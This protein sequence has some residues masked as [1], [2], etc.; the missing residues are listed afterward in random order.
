MRPQATIRPNLFIIGAAKAGTTTLH[1][2]LAAH[3]DVFMSEPKEPGYFTPEVGYYP[4][5]LEWY[6][7]LFKEAGDATIVGEAST[8]YTKRP[9]YEGVPKRIAE[10]CPDARFIYLMRDPVDRAVSHYWHEVRKLNEHRSIFGAIQEDLRYTCLGDYQYQL[11]PY[12]DRF[13]R[14]RVLVLTFEELVSEPDAVLPGVYQWL[15]LDH[16][17]GGIEL[18]RENARPPAMEKVRGLGLLHRFSRT[19]LWEA[20]HGYVPST[21]KDFGHRLARSEVRPDDVDST[22]VVEYLRPKFQQKVGELEA[23]LGRGFGRWT[24]TFPER[25][26]ASYSCDS[27]SSPER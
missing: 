19:G 2:H 5:D 11:E 3:P 10:F 17:A 12:F 24:T 23:F 4:T 1:R 20:I 9:L 13:G 6:L 25:V 18:G 21:L 16:P 8:H 27:Q 15:G 7:G 22:P 14:E 26:D